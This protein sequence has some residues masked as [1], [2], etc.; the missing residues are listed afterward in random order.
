MLIS[1]LLCVAGAFYLA[2]TTPERYRSQIG[3]INAPDTL[4]PSSGLNIG[5]SFGAILG[6]QGG[7]GT[8][9][10]TV[11]RLLSLSYSV[12]FFR[13]N[14]DLLPEL[15]PDRWNEETGWESNKPKGIIAKL[16]DVVRLSNSQAVKIGQNGPS[17]WELYKRLNKLRWVEVNEA[18]SIAN[19]VVEWESA[20]TAARVANA[21][22]EDFNSV[23]ANRAVKDTETN[24]ELLSAQ[25]TRTNVPEV[26]GALAELIADEMKR[27]VLA[28]TASNYA[29]EVINPAAPSEDRHWPKRTLIMIIGVF[30]GVCLGTAAALVLDNWRDGRRRSQT[31]T[32]SP[33]DMG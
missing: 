22:I 17:D 27:N 1:I 10:V 9:H 18:T 3:F 26:R 8:I 29:V 25:I 33:P 24:I 5:G 31:S 2:V 23:L 15:F 7:E 21:M 16:K 14:Q 20:K 13:R 12:D 30:A 6:A 4:A 32:Q 28:R 19:L 11:E